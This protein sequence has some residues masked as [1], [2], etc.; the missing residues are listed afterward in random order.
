MFE[1]IGFEPQCAVCQILQLWNVDNPRVEFLIDGT[2][3]GLLKS[4]PKLYLR[5]V[6]ISHLQYLADRTFRSKLMISNINHLFLYLRSLICQILQLWNVDN[7]QVEFL[8]DEHNGAFWSRI[9]KNNSIPKLWCFVI[10]IVLPKI[11]KIFK[12]TRTIH[13][14]CDKSEQFLVSECFFNLFLEVSHI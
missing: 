13:L 3:W 6:N 7:P 4:H 2:Q 5:I 12:I 8:I 9:R 1:I 10:K 11:C 14:N